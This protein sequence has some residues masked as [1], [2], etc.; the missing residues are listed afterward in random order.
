MKT[1]L[2]H[3]AIAAA[4]AAGVIGSQ[5]SYAEPVPSGAGVERRQ[6]AAFSS[7]ELSGPY[8]VAIRAGGKPGIE[9][10]GDPKQLQEVETV[11]RGDTLIV[12]PVK[13]SGF[14]FGIER[15]RDT[16]TVNISAASLNS[17]K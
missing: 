11:V 3:S 10:S 2:K 14:F 9:L 1:V 5:L 16:V 8:R 17:L 4:I 7:I 13:R 12:R 15:R 6:V